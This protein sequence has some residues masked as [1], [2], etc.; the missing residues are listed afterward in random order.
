MKSKRSR[1][2]YLKYT[3]FFLLAVG[4]ER[5]CYQQTAGFRESKILSTLDCEEK[6][7]TA[8]LTQE[9]KE[10]LHAILDQPFYYAGHGG[11]SYC[12]ASEDGCYVVKFFKHQHL[13]ESSWLSK[14]KL[15]S[16]FEERR[17]RYLEKKEK[18]QI[19]KRRDFLFTSFLLAGEHIPE[20]T[21]IIHL[22]LNKSKD[23]AKELVIYDKIGVQHK[24]PLDQT[25]FVLQRK[26]EMIFPYLYRLIDANKIDEAK[27]AIDSL[28]ANLQTRCSK[29]LADRDPHLSINFGYIDGKAVEI[30]IG[31]F[32]LDESLKDT[33][34]QKEVISVI[35]RSL[36]KKLSARS[37][38]ELEEYTN[39]K[40]QSP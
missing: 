27:R 36:T 33:A 39:R 13:K 20:E 19:H 28:F 32:S 29:G 9:K 31:S 3:F 38:H 25:E 4:V 12:F 24:I 17:Q 22:Q 8:P 15:P 35:A 16:F 30:D 14:V 11:T 37:A 2:K 34:R 23:F 40:L 7:N 21:G 6:W 1:K 10:Q 18:K 5:F 26:A